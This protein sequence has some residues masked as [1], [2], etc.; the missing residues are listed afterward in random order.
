MLPTEWIAKDSDDNA[1]STASKAAPTNNS[2]HVIAVVTASYSSSSTTG[3]LQVKEGTTVIHEHY[4]HGADVIPLEYRAA[5][6]TAVSAELAA[7]GTG[8]VVGKVA[9]IGHTT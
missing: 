6:N 4:V 7:S 1:L 5:V 3:L 8:G 9:V 2:R